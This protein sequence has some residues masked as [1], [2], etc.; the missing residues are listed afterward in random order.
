MQILTN[1]KYFLAKQFP[2]N[3]INISQNE[4]INYFVGIY[5]LL[6]NAAIYMQFGL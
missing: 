6:Y 2:L 4:H 5:L 3:F 1:W